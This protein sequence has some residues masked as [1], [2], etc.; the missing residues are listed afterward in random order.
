LSCREEDEM[1][2]VYMHLDVLGLPDGVL[3]YDGFLEALWGELPDA[4]WVGAMAA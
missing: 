2:N 4:E 3:D 1:F